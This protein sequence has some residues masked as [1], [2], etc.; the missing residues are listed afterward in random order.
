MCVQLLVNAI[1]KIKY[2]PQSLKH[3]RISHSHGFPGRKWESY[4]S[5]ITFAYILV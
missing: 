2:M 3:A 1:R 4:T 5:N